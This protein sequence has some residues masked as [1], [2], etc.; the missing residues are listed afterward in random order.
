M[1]ARP[2]TEETGEG[3]SVCV[4]SSACAQNVVL[5]PFGIPIRGPWIFRSKH[6][7][8]SRAP[9]FGQ[10]RFYFTLATVRHFSPLLTNSFAVS[11]GTVISLPFEGRF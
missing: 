8:I 7:G 6:A 5:V 3:F 9:P 4:S 2:E 10:T 11:S 1:L